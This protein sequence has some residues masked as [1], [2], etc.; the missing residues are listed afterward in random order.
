MIANDDY[1]LCLRKHMRFYRKGMFM[2]TG[3]DLVKIAFVT[4]HL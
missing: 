1:N 3:N 4:D 2:I